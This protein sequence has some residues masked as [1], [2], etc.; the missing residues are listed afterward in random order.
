MSIISVHRPPVKPTRRTPRPPG[1][2]GAGLFTFIPLA[3][4]ATGFVEPSDEDR[5]AV[6]AIFA[7]AEPDYEDRAAEFEWNRQFEDTAPLPG[8][9]RSCGQPAELDRFGYCD[10]CNVIIDKA[11]DSKY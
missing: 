6:V 8:H 9:C 5:A 3:V 11:T 4:M 10:P 1:P 7:D 2:F